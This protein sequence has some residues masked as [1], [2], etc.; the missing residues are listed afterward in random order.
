MA[1]GNLDVDQM[2]SVVAGIAEGCKQ[3]GSALIGGETAEM[4]G[5]YSGTDY[6]LAGFSV[7][8]AERGTLLDG[9]DVA[10]G[11]ILIGLPSSGIHSNGY[12]LVRRIIDDKGYNYA[13]PAPF[14][15][16]VTLGEALL[17]P[18]RIYVKSCL[19][20][21]K[22]KCV[23]AFSHITGGG[24]L[25][26]LPRVLPEGT[27]A[28][29][30]ADTW[31]LLPIFSWLQNEGNIETR[32]MARTFNCGMG[33]IIIVDADKSNQSMELLKEAGET[34]VI[35]GKVTTS[36]GK[37]DCLVSGSAGTWGSNEDWSART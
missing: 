37:P 12:S 26:N 34:P 24:F 30:D 1:T 32:E 11:D 23:K 5:M 31:D 25:E 16:T 18:T 8:A 22:N 6:D 27:S 10:A 35:V 19:Q 33:M 36:D 13:S 14:D 3:S 2:T 21:V 20:L 29:I 9:S 28:E 15:D 7:G 17:A 4:P